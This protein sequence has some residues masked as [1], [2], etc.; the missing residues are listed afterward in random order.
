MKLTAAKVIMPV[1]GALKSSTAA[2]SKRH[3]RFTIPSVPARPM[4]KVTR[5]AGSPEYWGSETDFCID[6]A[7]VM[8]VKHNLIKVL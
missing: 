3:R 7:M 8:L 2:A 5:D 4:S 6:G 1:N